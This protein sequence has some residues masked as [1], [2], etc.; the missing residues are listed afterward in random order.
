MPKNPLSRERALDVIR[1]FMA[2]EGM[3]SLDYFICGSIR[4]GLKEVGDIDIIVVGE[5]PDSGPSK[6]YYESGAKKTRTYMYKKAQINMWTCS[7][8][9]LG[10]F[11]L[12]ATGSGSF[13]RFLRNKAISKKMKLS[14]HGL[15]NRE[16][17]DLIVRETEKEIFNK[18][19]LKYIPPQDRNTKKTTVLMKAFSLRSK[20]DLSYVGR[21]LGRVEDPSIY[22][23]AVQK[24]L[25]Y[26]GDFILPSVLSVAPHLHAFL[27]KK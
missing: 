24:F 19:G 25:P 2:L 7:P 13:N 1:D 26:T 6:A 9:A 10:S 18:L 8:D 17:G 12:Y 22:P 14:Q 20:P 21:L 11:I 15:F 23:K 3:S 27:G 5:F 4:R 16:T